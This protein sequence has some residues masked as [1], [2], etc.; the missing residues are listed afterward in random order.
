MAIENTGY[1]ANAKL[2]K[3]T[4]DGT[5]RPLDDN[6]N[7]SSESGLNQSIKNNDFTD[8]DY[9]PPTEN[10]TECPLP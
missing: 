10:Q 2:V 8:D 4:T 5:N 7:L 3:V 1:L 9:L 6:N